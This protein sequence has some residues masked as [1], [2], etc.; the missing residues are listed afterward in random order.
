MRF[1]RILLCCVT[2]TCQ[3]IYAQSSVWKVES[4]NGQIYIGG[5][6]H[7]LKASDFPLPEPYHRALSK[8][9]HLVFETDIEVLTSP[10]GSQLV[11]KALLNE[12]EALLSSLLR[13]ETLTALEQQLAVYGLSL[14]Q[15]NP[16]K[17]AMVALTL[18]MTE[19]S[20]LGVGSS[21]V[22]T[23]LYQLG[24]R[25]GKKISGLE[26]LQQQAAFI[27]NMGAK[28]PDGFISQT[29]AELSQT[30]QYYDEI[31]QAWRSGE[32][33]RITELLSQDYATNYPEQYQQ[34]I[35]DRNNNW[36][37]QIEALINSAE[38]SYVLVGLAHLAGDEGLIEQLSRKGYK[39]SQVE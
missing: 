10:E 39:I 28:D 37:P 2:F 16:Y 8:S 34:L 23:R 18:Q 15:F 14:A 35:I 5:T 24:K 27:A 7:L 22:D 33:K 3:A 20:K 9:S 13:N 4:A 19:L 30:Q 26:T 38:I 29:L 31:V 32:I 6:L 11:N 25:E 21:G 36:L 12:G 17:P 1:L